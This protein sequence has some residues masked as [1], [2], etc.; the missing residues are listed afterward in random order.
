[1]RARPPLTLT[2]ALLGATSRA[3]EPPFDFP[4]LLDQ[5]EKAKTPDER[6][7]DQWADGSANAGRR[8]VQ[9]FIPQNRAAGTLLTVRRRRRSSAL[10]TAW[11]IY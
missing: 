10:S 9:A 4:A 6:G 11:I 7:F 1:M 8:V 2:V 5:L 3:A